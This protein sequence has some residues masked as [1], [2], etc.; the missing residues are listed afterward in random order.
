MVTFEV[1][2]CRFRFVASES[3]HF[4]AGTS[5]NVLR[6][7]IG[8][9]LAE[10]APA[11]YARIFEPTGDSP[12][13]LANRPRPFVFRASHLDGRTI[14]PGESFEFD[15]HYF[16]TRDPA[17]ASFVPGFAELARAGLG[18]RRGRAT[19]VE[20]IQLDAHRRAAAKAAPPVA[21]A[22]D[23][24]GDGLR[25]LTVRFVTPTEL[26]HAEK[27]AER[28]E[29]AILFARVRDRV[30]TLRALYGAGPVDVDFRALGER[31]AAVRMTRC[32]LRRVELERRSSRTGQTHPLGGFIGEADYEGE[33]GEFL[34]WL[35]AAEWTGVGRQ[36]VWGKGAIELSA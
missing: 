25:R 20:V 23:T 36:T 16:D 3:I 7:A 4:P 14:R 26:K 1:L 28:P 35:R 8:A 15:L 29:F 21:I 18:P 24:R 9:I 2:P 30:A 33:L 31:A 34:G 5:G 32:D 11:A 22:L 6:G 17:L 27:V 19:L 13:G 10:L 12:S